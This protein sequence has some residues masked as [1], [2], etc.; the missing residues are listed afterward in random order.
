MSKQS[1][2]EKK[3]IE[4]RNIESKRNDYVVNDPYSESHEDAKT[5]DDENHPQ[6]KGT[7]KSLTHTIPHQY[8]STTMIVPQLDTE[9]GGGSFDKFGRNGIGGR[10]YL[11]NINIYNEN[12]QYSKDSVEISSEI[13]GQ[14]YVN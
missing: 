2:L 12:N 11:K 5:H 3:G 9:D 7:G 6:G 8:Q 1:Y 13:E 10:N 4:R 14:Y